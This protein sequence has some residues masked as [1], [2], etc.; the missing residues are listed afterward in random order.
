[1]I[2]SFCN[3]FITSEHIFSK[4]FCIIKGDLLIAHNPNCVLISLIDNIVESVC[5]KPKSL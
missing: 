4:L 5:K 2:S 3:I 1:M